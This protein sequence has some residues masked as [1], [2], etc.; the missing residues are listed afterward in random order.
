MASEPSIDPIALAARDITDAGRIERALLWLAEHWKINGEGPRWDGFAAQVRPS[1]ASWT[2][3]Q[4]KAYLNRLM[5]VLRGKNLIFYVDGGPAG[6]LRPGHAFY[7][8]HPQYVVV[9]IPAEL[10]A[11]APAPKVPRHAGKPGPKP[12]AK[13]SQRPTAGTAKTQSGIEPSGT[14]G[15]ATAI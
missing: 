13:P 5:S 14:P 2:R 1:S 6:H 4:R 3:V 9:P 8:A 10:A 7:R 12:G 15:G 11:K